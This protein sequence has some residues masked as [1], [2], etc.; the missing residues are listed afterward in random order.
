[1]GKKTL[2]LLVAL[3]A[4]LS[5]PRSRAAILDFA[6]PGLDPIRGQ[7]TDHELRKLA[8]KVL[9]YEVTFR[10]VPGSQREFVDF[11]NQRI[12]ERNER[13]DSWGNYYAL[14]VK[15]DSFFVESAGPDGK[16]GTDD[17]RVVGEHRDDPWR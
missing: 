14:R 16:R 2:F 6:K 10:R 3:G 9:E 4:G 12:L 7:I 5:F 13:T 1:V 11:M 17:D 8:R 15:A